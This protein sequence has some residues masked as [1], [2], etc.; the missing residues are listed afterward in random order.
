MNDALFLDD[1]SASISSTSLNASRFDVYTVHQCNVSMSKTTM[2]G[3]LKV[4]DN[5]K[6][7]WLNQFTVIV[8]DAD[9]NLVAGAPVTITDGTGK[10]IASGNTSSNGQFV[11]DV[12]GW[13]QTVDG[14]QS[15]TTPYWVNATVSGKSISQ[16]AY[17]S[18]SQTITAQAQRGVMDTVL[19]PL[20]LIAALVIAILVIVVVVRA[21]RKS[22]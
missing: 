1:C 11:A 15:V 16:T 8:K 2:D 9:G 5:G 21:R 4:E 12:A 19:L 22:A 20:L 6:I 18:Q 13:T 14:K 10:I 7:T 17:G 3:K